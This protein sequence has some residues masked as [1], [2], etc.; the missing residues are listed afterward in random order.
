KELGLRTEASYRFERGMDA[1][2][3]LWAARRG[4]E[5]FLELAGGELL[6]GAID[7]YPQPWQAPVL[8]LRASEI[9][10]IL[11]AAVPEAEVERILSALGFKGAR[12]DSGAWQVVGPP[13]R[14]DVSREIDVIEEIARLY[15]YHKF[16]PRL[17][18]ARQPI[19]VRAHAAAE[20]ALREALEAEG[21]DEAISFSPVNPQEAEKFLAPGTELARIAN[22]LSEEAAALRP[23]GLLSLVKALSWNLNRGQRNLRL[24]EIGRSYTARDRQ[25]HERRVL[26]LAGSGL[27]REKSAHQPEQP[28]DLFALKGAVEAAA[29]PFALDALQ[30]EPCEAA[31]F[32]PS[33][34]A[35]VLAGTKR[36][37][38]LGRL[39]QPLAADFKLRQDAWLAELDLETLC[40]AGVR[41][42]RYRPLSRFPA[43]SRD[44]SLLLRERVRFGAV[45]SAIEDLGLAELV[46][47]AAVDRF[48]SSKLPAGHY[49]L[50]IRIVFQSAQQTLTDEQTRAY[51]ERIIKALEEKLGARLR[52]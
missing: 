13:W 38:T 18:P 26:T 14:R 22:P 39:S 15:G 21:Y 44:F 9:E 6:A 20:K 1:E 42:R 32:H 47:V 17:P 29:A 28:Y 31:C 45:R 24:Y 40:G 7:V 49:S 52:A 46:S 48:R 11:G 33:E 34:R 51:S 30:F 12:A 35:A 8:Q 19:V 16:P 10:R 25:F 2:A 4:A 36:L 41:A 50:L 43:V 27:L 37:G 23:T 3:P 5:L